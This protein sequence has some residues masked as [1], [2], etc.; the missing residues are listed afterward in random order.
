MRL[1]KVG[2][3]A[4]ELEKREENGKNLSDYQIGINDGL[5]IA[6]MAVEDAP[7]VEAIPIP[8]IWDFMDHI[9]EEIAQTDDSDPR[10]PG[11]CARHNA[12]NALLRAWK[13]EEG[14][15]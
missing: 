14:K 1:V 3:L 13:E 8:F 12:L 5:Q 7:T 15:R 2:S 11:L 4:E 6:E 10:M 9:E